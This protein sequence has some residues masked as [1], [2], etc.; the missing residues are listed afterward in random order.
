MWVPL[1]NKTNAVIRFHADGFD[2]AQSWLMGRQM[3]GHGFLRAAVKARGRGPLFGY[4][5]SVQSARAFATMVQK[6]D[7]A[8][9]PVWIKG[10]AI[11]VSCRSHAHS[12]GSSPTE[13][14]SRALLLVRGDA[15]DRECTNYGANCRTSHRAGDAVGCAHLHF[16]GCRRN[17]PQAQAEF[18]RWRLGDAIRLSKP[19]IP[20]IPLGVHCSDFAFSD[21]DRHLAHIA[22]GI[23]RED[24][25][26]LYVGRFAFSGKAHPFQ[27]YQGPSGRRGANPAAS[28]PDPMRL[29][30]QRRYHRG[31]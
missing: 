20:V 31:V 16:D 13:G 12:L 4:G 22:L 14:G 10:R 2:I 6:V 21:E 25:A 28:R 30:C 26:A 19:E 8:A 17:C 5:V 9:E 15:Y 24:V 23:Q 27:M 18:L 29:G 3:A 7:S 11:A 1:P